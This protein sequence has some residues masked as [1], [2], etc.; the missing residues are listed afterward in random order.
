MNTKI[1]K[2]APG[3]MAEAVDTMIERTNQVLAISTRASE[4]GIKDL[5]N[6]N[7]FDD[8]KLAII[9]DRMPEINR[10]TKA[11]G[12]QNSQTTSKL[13]SL[14]MLNTGPYHRLKQCLAQIERKR[15]ALKEN[16]FKMQGSAL[17]LRKHE[18]KREDLAEDI[19]LLTAELEA[20]GSSGEISDDFQDQ[21]RRLERK[22]RDLHFEEDAL[23]IKV[24]KIIAGLVDSQEYYEAALKEIGIFQDSYEQIKIS[25][26]IPDTWDEQD[27]EEAECLAHVK[28]AFNHGIRDIT[29]HGKLGMG[30]LEY[31]E[32]F[33]VNPSAA[34]SLIHGY[35]ADN[36]AMLDGGEKLPHIDNLHSFLD[37][38]G[39]LFK[40]SYLD[41]LK[42]VGLDTLMSKWCIYVDPERV[43]AREAAAKA[44]NV[45]NANPGDE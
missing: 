39:E 10:A 25:N 34:E 4:D 38:M 35:L 18:A 44:A 9:T 32:Q 22:I 11:F 7:T 36:A 2:Y 29:S 40:D 13:M 42:N 5:I 16:T 37:E 33:G 27:Y 6:F 30:T 24:T 21:A 20:L 31:L 17:K 45:A 28:T 14:T 15:G 41:A 23:D 1:I 26:N 8:K 12:K 19:A 3:I 43:K